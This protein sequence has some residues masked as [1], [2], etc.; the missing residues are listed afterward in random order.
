MENRRVESVGGDP[1][2]TRILGPGPF[3]E[4]RR[5]HYVHVLSHLTLPHL[6]IPYYTLPYLTLTYPILP[7]PNL[8][9]PTLPYLI[10]S[11]HIISYRILT[12]TLT[13]DIC[14]R[15]HFIIRLQLSSYHL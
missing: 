8:S 7:Y 10:L 9:Y 1:M 3:F 5:V 2:I 6:T 4:V 15:L 12:I 13:E 11:Y 14:L